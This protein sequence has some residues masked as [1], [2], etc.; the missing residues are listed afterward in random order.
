MKGL[1]VKRRVFSGGPAAKSLLYEKTLANAGI[2]MV[3]SK[4]ATTDACKELCTTM[5]A[6]AKNPPSL[7]ISG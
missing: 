3:N 2:H 6:T 4:V 5:L 7:L 1:L